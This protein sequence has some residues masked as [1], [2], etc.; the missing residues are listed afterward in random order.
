MDADARRGTLLVQGMSDGAH[1]AAMHPRRPELAIACYNG[2]VYLWDR[3][4]KV[5]LMVRQFDASR[6]RP[7]ALAY[8]P[9]GSY[10]LVGLPPDEQLH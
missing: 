8:D 7:R 1:G 5:L 2:A 9:S 6:L 10:L 3:E 4:T